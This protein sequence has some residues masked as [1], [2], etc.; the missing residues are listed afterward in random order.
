MSSVRL[1]YPKNHQ[2][3]VASNILREILSAPVLSTPT[4]ISSGT[5]SNFILWRICD[6]VC[7]DYQISD[8]LCWQLGTLLLSQYPGMDWLKLARMA[9]ARSEM[10]CKYSFFIF[11]FI[12]PS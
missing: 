1:A 9:M 11:V 10:V 7:Q 6:T 12:H 8:K 5:T 4:F 3:T 2:R